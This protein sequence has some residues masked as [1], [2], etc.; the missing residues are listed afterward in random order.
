MKFFNR[1]PFDDQKVESI[2]VQIT[3]LSVTGTPIDYQVFLDDVE[4][5]PRTSNPELFTS[6][7]DL[8]NEKSRNLNI[9]VFSGTT[10]HKRTYSFYFSDAPSQSGELN[11]FDARQM[12]DQQV[13]IETMK[14]KISIGEQQLKQCQDT[15]SE[16]ED[17]N[18]RLSKE[19]IE[20]RDDLKKALSENGIASTVIQGVER[21]ITQLAPQRSTG[22][23]AGTPAQNTPRHGTVSITAEQH[24]DYQAFSALAN[25]FEP[26][27]F[28][29]VLRVLGILAEDK[30]T[31]AET[32]EFLTQSNNQ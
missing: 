20:L 32:L 13:S 27:E 12:I 19:N 10:R 5:I 11:G 16:L 30:S 3:N 9:N 7:Y 23:L 28:D 17:E 29:N 24:A 14:I 6:F 21:V 26:S 8:I 22:A 18:E 1:E 25:R 15:I 2:R 4:V 31:I